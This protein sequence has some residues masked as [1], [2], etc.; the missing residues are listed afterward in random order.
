MGRR[1][2]ATDRLRAV[3]TSHSAARLIDSLDDPSPEVARAAIQRLAKIE[4]S[5][6]APPLRARLLD[7]DLALVSEIAKALRRV[8]DGG[9]V[10]VA[11]VGLSDER[12]LRRLA[13]AKALGVFGDARGV[14]ALRAALED[15]IAG[16]RMAALEALAAIRAPLDA[17]R[18]CGRLLRDPDPHVRIAAVRA[19]VR[20]TSRP[21]T[22]IASLAGDDDRVVRLEVARNLAGLPEHAA[23]ALLADPDVRVREAAAQAAGIGQAGQL[24]VRLLE[25]PNADVRRAAAQTLGALGDKRIADSLIRGL[26]DPDAVV[27]AAALRSIKRLLTRAEAIERLCRE[28]ASARPERRRASVYALAHLDAL[29]AAEHVAALADDPDDDVRLALIHAARS[30]LPDPKTVIG[31]LA[32]DADGAVRSSAEI[33]LLRARISDH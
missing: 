2:D 17:G 1:A 30:L 28:L 32:L 4:G 29:E 6:A 8:G 14:G 21:G 20:T 13:A 25:D 5:S 26:E 9:A 7:A 23:E 3:L 22:V 10:D 16:V 15:E 18:D 19:L 24:S 11:L 27:R 33:W 31:E 12:Y